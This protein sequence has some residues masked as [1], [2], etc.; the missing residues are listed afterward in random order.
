MP[1]ALVGQILSPFVFRG[2]TIHVREPGLAF[3][4]DTR[5]VHTRKYNE[6]APTETYL[7][8]LGVHCTM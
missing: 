4:Q 6:F 7:Y 3:G 2:T 8:F 5:G 1:L